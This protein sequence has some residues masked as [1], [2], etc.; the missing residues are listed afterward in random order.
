MV[1]KFLSRVLAIAALALPSVA[2]A[3]WIEATTK[4]FTIYSDD[5][6]A[7]VSKFAL[8]LE[9]Y[10]K[11]MRVFRHV[12]DGPVAPVDRVTIFVT[13]S[14]KAIEALSQP[15][16]AGFYR[17]VAGASVAFTAKRGSDFVPGSITRTDDRWQ[18]DPQT[19]LRHEYAH[20]FMFSNWDAAALP[21]WFSEGF[22]EFHATAVEQ[23]DGT[24][25]FG[26][27]PGYRLGHFAYSELCSAGRI[28]AA[29]DLEKLTGCGIGDLYAY[30]WLLTSYFTFSD[31]GWDKLSG[32]VQAINAGKPAHEAVKAFGDLTTLDAT[33]KH[34]LDQK[35]LPAYRVVAADLKIEAPAL[36]T[37]SAGEAAT[38]QVRM[39][40]KAG[41]DKKEAPG[42]YAEAVR[43]AAPYPNDPAAQMV[44]AE[45][46]FDAKQYDACEAAAKRALAAN[47][48]LTKAMLYIGEAKMARAAEAKSADAAVWKDVR[49]WFL[50]ANQTD[51]DDPAPLILFY[52]SYV[53]AGIPATPSARQGL[54][55]AIDVAPYDQSLTFVA[56]YAYLSDNKL[57]Q[58]KAALAIRAYDPDFAKARE[59]SAKLLGM[60][61]AG[62]TGEAMAVLLPWVK[63]PAY[64][65]PEDKKKKK[66]D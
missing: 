64:E 14:T 61:D 59:R 28:V 31:G 58:A 47:P 26:A 50:T 17:G 51:P 65:D 1:R 48:K 44:L 20:H 32:Y 16:V 25:V 46:A 66:G 34:Y 7:N 56:A 35:K 42:V 22:A 60:I 54:Y 12:E 18:L 43:A 37:V 23:P 40:S 33:L 13:R 29:D 2:H 3:E 39:Q 38:M 57:P 27:Q 36:R 63:D 21:M 19:V 45:A 4:H 15:G 41:V 55:H 11:A 10:D 5:S 53:V 62:K 9:R 8:S 24:V 49:H 30:G 52:R 6:A